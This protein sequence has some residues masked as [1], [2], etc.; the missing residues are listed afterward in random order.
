MGL[1]EGSEKLSAILS[2]IF[3]GELNNLSELEKKAFLG[4][5]LASGRGAAAALAARKGTAGK[6]GKFLQRPIQNPIQTATLGGA[7]KVRQLRSPLGAAPASSTP[8]APSG[9]GGPYRSLG[10]VLGPKK[11]D[12]RHVKSKSLVRT[13]A[14]TAAL[15]GTGYLAYKGIPAAARFAEQ[16]SSNP[17]AYNFGHQQFQYGY[18]PE[19][20]AQF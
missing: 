15:L 2:T 20:Q 5:L 16:A 17:M 3:S 10:E 13:L 19:G 11:S 12:V 4:R 1:N 14:P 9:K 7:G 18:T 8:L 6:V